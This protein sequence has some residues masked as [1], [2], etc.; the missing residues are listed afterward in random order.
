VR[1][2]LSTHVSLVTLRGEQRTT[3]IGAASEML[4]D[5]CRALVRGGGWSGAQLC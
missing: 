1:P 3:L 5:V 4:H 2:T